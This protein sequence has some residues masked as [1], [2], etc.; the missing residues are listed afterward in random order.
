MDDLCGH[1]G[2][3]YKFDS[4]LIYIYVY[5]FMYIYIYFNR[6]APVSRRPGPH[7]SQQV[8]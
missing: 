3:T 7:A 2:L 6:L 8:V 5:I 1:F 4:V